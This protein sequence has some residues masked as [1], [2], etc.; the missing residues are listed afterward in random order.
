MISIAAAGDN[1][2]L[3]TKTDDTSDQYILILCNA[4]G[5]P[6]DSKYTEVEPL[7]ITMTRH[8]IAVSSEDYV[9]VWQYRAMLSTIDNRGVIGGTS[10][11]RKEGKEKLFHVDDVSSSDTGKLDFKR[12]N[13]YH[14]L[15]FS[16]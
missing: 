1:C 9:Y 3:V 6:V 4:I 11:L 14:L 2:V 10:L 12:T 16:F 7:V 13:A 8:H 5:T 15:L